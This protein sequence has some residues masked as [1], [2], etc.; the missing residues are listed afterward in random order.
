VSPE[1][2]LMRRLL[3]HNIL[4]V[5]TVSKNADE[6]HVPSVERARA[7]HICRMARIFVENCLAGDIVPTV[8]DIC[9]SV[10]VSERSLQYAFRTYVDLSPLVYLRLCR[11]NRVRATLRSSHPQITTV[12]AVAMRFGFLHLGRFAVDYKQIFNE[13]P[14]ATLAS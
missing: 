7:F 2:D 11:L 13:S 9:K 12:T 6:S 4:Q 14:S 8:V 10:S 5:A 3:L 1:I